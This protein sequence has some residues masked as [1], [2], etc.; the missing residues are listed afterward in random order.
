[1]D[2]FDRVRPLVE[3][4][5]L[6]AERLL[7]V[8]REAFKPGQNH[9]AYHLAAL[10]LEEVGKASI[11]TIDAIHDSRIGMGLADEDEKR[12]ADW[13]E[14]HERKLFWAL[15]LPRFGSR[16]MSVEEFRSFQ[17]IARKIHDLRLAT[18]YVSPETLGVEVTDRDVRSLIDLTA[19][20]LEMERAKE[21]QAPEPEVQADMEWFFRAVEHPLLKTLVL[22]RGSLDK[23]AEFNGDARNW[24]RWLRETVEEMN[25]LNRELAETELKRPTPEE[26]E[27]SKP[28]W[29][30]TLRFKSSSHSIRPKP[31]AKWNEKVD[32]IKF[33]PTADKKELLVKMTLQKGVLVNALWNAGFH[34]STLVILSLNI[35]TLG[36]FWWY[37]PSMTRKYYDKITD[38]ENNNASLVLDTPSLEM[39]FGHRA[40]KE[41]EL[42]NV[43]LVLGYLLRLDQ[44][45]LVPFGRYFQVL[46]VIAKNDLLGNFHQPLMNELL[47]TLKSALLTFGDWDGRSE[48]FDP[49]VEKVFETFGAD[50]LKEVKD[51]I[52]LARECGK[53]PVPVPIDSVLKM[54]AF[55]ETFFITRIKERVRKEIE[56]HKER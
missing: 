52:K 38:L 47:E 11:F 10:A 50:F 51:I 29:E 23:L 24:I 14:D 7:D 28:R 30:I 1:M 37:L 42:I 31:L 27:A 41:P 49:A 16:T 48:A 21:H 2:A 54:K 22:S 17:E 8:A 45:E 33:Y 32:S 44:K 15:W 6:N 53:K 25:R 3:A 19:A 43:S 55:C 39:N 40:L 13:I 20:R 5:L 35:G 18:L 46:G 36:F 12:P 26:K 4:C 56:A 34:L 9:I